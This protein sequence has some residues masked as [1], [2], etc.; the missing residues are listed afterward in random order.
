MDHQT[1][2]HHPLYLL[3]FEAVNEAVTRHVDSR[4]DA[5]VSRYLAGLLVTFSHTDQVFRIHDREGR[6][7]VTIS[8]M[9]SEGDIRANA[10]SFAR[11]RQVHQHIADFILFWTGVYPKYL[12]SMTLLSDAGEVIRDY[13]EQA[14]ESYYLVSHYESLQNPDEAQTYRQLG[15]GFDDYVFCLG[16]VRT[17]LGL[18]GYAMG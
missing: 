4:H 15:E 11:E 8:D 10:D 17:R 3:F 5:T 7:L 6:R 13:R 18:D 14:R 2:G 12:R 9:L 1:F 16:A